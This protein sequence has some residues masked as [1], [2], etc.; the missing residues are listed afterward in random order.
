V[1]VTLTFKFPLAPAATDRGFGFTET[2]L[3]PVL[4]VTTDRT[5]VAD[6]AELLTA[7]CCVCGTVDPDAKLKFKGVGLADNVEVVFV[8]VE[9][10]LS[11][12]GTLIVLFA[13]LMVTKPACA[14]AARLAGFA[15]RLI[16]SG[17]DPLDGLT[18]NQP[19]EKTVVVIGST[20][21]L[22]VIVKG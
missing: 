9:T 10:I 4:V 6:T 5:W 13:L 20:P 2:Q 16:A 21:A 19:S 11:V 18:L 22:D 15:V 3:P 7:N 8:P 14:P 12:T 1:G 17:V